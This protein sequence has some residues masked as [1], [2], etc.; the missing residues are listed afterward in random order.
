MQ[1]DGT[2]CNSDTSQVVCSGVLFGWLFVSIHPSMFDHVMF[3][4]KQHPFLS[5]IRRSLLLGG[6]QIMYQGG[7]LFILYIR[8]IAIPRVISASQY[9]VQFLHRLNIYP[10]PLIK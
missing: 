10:R 5:N 8:E 2:V 4:Y 9:L 6:L 7:Y 3:D 1:L